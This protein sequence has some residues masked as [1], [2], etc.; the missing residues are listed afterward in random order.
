NS[1][2]S[3][4][5]TSSP[6]PS[7]GARSS[8]PLT[9]CT[10]LV[11]VVIALARLGA[12]ALGDLGGA[13]VRQRR[14]WSRHRWRPAGA[15]GPFDDADVHDGAHVPSLTILERELRYSANRFFGSHA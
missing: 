13:D 14:D 11:P 8:T 5:R 2:A 15:G 9:A 3:S 4:V 7:T 10:L 6:R 12:R 1:S